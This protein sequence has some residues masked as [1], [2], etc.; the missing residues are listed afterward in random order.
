[1]EGALLL[2]VISSPAL[3]FVPIL[4]LEFDGE[5]VKANSSPALP[6]VPILVLGFDGELVKAAL[7]FAPSNKATSRVVPATATNTSTAK[8]VVRDGF[9]DRD[10]SSVLLSL[11]LTVVVCVIMDGS[12]KGVELDVLAYPK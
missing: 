12:T 6:F 11:T 2:A 9:D 8:S 3:P 5:L 1:M 10:A 4:V 7:E